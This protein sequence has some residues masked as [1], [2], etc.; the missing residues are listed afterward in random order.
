MNVKENKVG[1]NKNTN[2]NTPQTNR[3]NKYLNKSKN[4]KI[5]KST[6]PSSK[7]LNNPSKNDSESRKQSPK[8]QI[9]NL[10]QL[11]ET[12]DKE[13]KSINEE[14]KN[15]KIII[16]E[17]Q[18]IITDNENKI[19]ILNNEIYILKNKNELLEKDLNDKLQ[20][21]KELNNSLIEYQ[22]KIKTNE[23]SI[24]FI[25]KI[26]E[27]DNTDKK[28]ENYEIELNKLRNDLNELEIKNS[29]LTFDKTAKFNQ[30]YYIEL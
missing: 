29:Q 8:T 19:E 6:K 22:Q 16:L 21:M 30:K 2:V 12:K 10:K 28:I 25:N 17:K 13:I 26:K 15:N 14:N 5:I 3:P 18:K 20:K 11:I 1:K 9:I 7:T 27:C 24:N 23:E 4:K